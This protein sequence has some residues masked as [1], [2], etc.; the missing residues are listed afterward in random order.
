MN[1]FH[2][3]GILHARNSPAPHDG[4]SHLTVVMARDGS[5]T[6]H[7]RPDGQVHL[8][9]GMFM[10]CDD[11]RSMSLAAGTRLHRMSVPISGAEMLRRMP[12][13][14][15]LIGRPMRSHGAGGLFLDH[16]RSLM[17]HFAALPAAS[18]ELVLDTT[19]EL[20]RACLHEQPELPSPRL[21]RFSLQ[22]VQRHIER[23][24]T[25]PELGVTSLARSFRMSQRNLHKLFAGT[26]TTVSAYI[27]ERRLAMC[28]RDLV[29][30]SLMARQ[31]AEIALHWGFTDPGHFSKL[32]R[33][34][35]GVS[36]SEWRAQAP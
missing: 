21:G 2:D 9:E 8:A 14:R 10:L 24:L 12:R 26:G 15:D 18:R 29:S 16:C 13:M 27:R 28:R 25:D 30:R 11:T 35:Y 32:F 22:Q 4:D 19:L 1:T 3:E 17:L 20:L 34:A 33:A 23:H 36:P 5:E 6:L 31:V 7:L